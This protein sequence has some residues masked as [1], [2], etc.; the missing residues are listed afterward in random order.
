MKFLEEHGISELFEPVTKNTVTFK[1]KLPKKD[2][3]L[4]LQKAADLGCDTIE[5]YLI[6]IANN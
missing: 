3:E 5:E 1:V 2:Y 6:K 4:I